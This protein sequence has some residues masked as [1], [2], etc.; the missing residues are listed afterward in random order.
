MHDARIT[1]QVKVGGGQAPEL[2]GATR[3]GWHPGSAVGS[4]GAPRTDTGTANPAMAAL[5]NKLLSSLLAFAV[6]GLAMWQGA[7]ASFVTQ[8][9]NPNEGISTGIVVMTNV[10]GS[11]VSGSNCSGSTLNGTCATTFQTSN[12]IPGEV[13]KT[14]TVT[15]TYTGTIGTG[16]F[17]LYAGNYTSKATGSTG[18]CTATDPASKLDLQIQQGSTIIYPTSGSGYGT[19]SGFAA[20]FASAA[21]GLALKGGTNG[22]GSPGV[23]TTNDSSVFQVALHLDTSAG[24]TYA[25]CV[26]V[27]DLF[28]NGAQ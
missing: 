19:L 21:S 13:D 11:V 28:W 10:A 16:N 24:S 22:L 6:M 27:A 25:G 15:I 3:V 4:H 12:D 20:T 1:A 5:A 23:W 18:S 8:A 7:F 14:N 9:A 2:R 26:S 17:V